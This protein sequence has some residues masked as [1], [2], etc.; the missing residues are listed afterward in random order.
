MTAPARH[1]AAPSEVRLATAAMGTRFELVLLGNDRGALQAAGE[2]ALARIE[3]AHQAFSRF[4][5]ASLI[6]HLRRCAPTPVAIDRETLAFFET[7]AAVARASDRAFNP[8]YD[9]PAGEAEWPVVDRQHGTVAF[10]S[11][12]CDPDFGG[13]AKGFAIDWAVTVLRAAGIRRAFL[14]GG[15]SSAYGLGAPPGKAGWRVALGDRMGDPVVSLADRGLACS[16]T[17]TTRDGRRISH[18]V[19]PRIH[20]IVAVD[21][22][23]V[24]VGPSAGLADAWATAALVTGARPEAMDREWDFWIRKGEGPWR[25]LTTTA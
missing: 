2:T 4:D 6:A 14:Q 11:A 1:R 24:V 3:E 21:R 9:S 13:C 22:R 16:A 19:D 23:V 17:M 8:Y 5:S 12:R 25:P 18:V 20:D 10:P 15:A 7:V